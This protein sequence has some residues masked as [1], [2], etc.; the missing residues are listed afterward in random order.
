[1][2]IDPETGLLDQAR[3]AATPNQDERPAG[4]EPELIVIHC[5]SLPPGEFGGPHIDNLFAN[6]LETDAHPYFAEISDMRVSAHLLI[7]RDGEIIQYVPFHARAWHAG[8]SSYCGRSACNDFSIGIELEGCEK[9]P[10]SSEQYERLAEAISALLRRY[11]SL[12]RER[13]SGHSDISPGR[14]TDPGDVFDW[15]R[16]DQL[17]NHRAG[18]N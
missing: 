14:K 1:M 7:R 5:I 17:L 11:E 8:E 12:S 16:L 9:T 10:Y 3:Q 6:C 13:I 4:S 2:N 18:R 15:D